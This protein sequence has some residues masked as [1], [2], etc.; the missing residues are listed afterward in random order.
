MVYT[1]QDLSISAGNVRKDAF[2]T[3]LEARNWLDDAK[4]TDKYGNAF[5]PSTM[6]VDD[7]LTQ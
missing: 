4:H 7:F 2:S 3:L 6:T 5:T 1:A